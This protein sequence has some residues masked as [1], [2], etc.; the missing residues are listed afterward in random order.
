MSQNSPS[1]A[2]RS[3]QSIFDSALEAYKKKTGKDLT[4]DPLLPSLET[5]NSPDA[6]LAI[7]RAQILEPGQPQSSRNKLTMWLDPIVNVL[8]A[9]TATTG[10]FV[11]LAYPPVGVIFTG[12]GVLLSAA[13]GISADRGALID[14]FERIENIFRRLETYIEVPP[15]PGMTDA[16]VTVMVEVLR[17][18][19]IATKEVEQNRAKKFM[20]KLVGRTD[21]EDAL[22]RLEKVTLEEARMATAEALKAIHGVGNQVGDK[23]DGV[24]DKLKIVEDKM[25]V[26]EGILQCVDDKVKEIS[27]KVITEDQSRRDAVEWLSPPDPSINYNIARDTHHKGTGLWFTESSVFRDWKTSGSLLWINGKPGSGKSVLTSAIIQDIERISEAGS[28]HMAYF[29]FDFKDTGKQDSPHQRGAQRPSDSALMQ[30]L[31]KMF[32]VTEFPLYLIELVELHLANLRLCITSRS[33]VD[34]RN[35]LEPLTSISNRISLHDEVGQKKDIAEYISSIVYS[36]KKIMRWREEDKDLVVKTLSDR[37][38][39]MFRWV[40]CQIE[41]LRRCLAPSL[42][43]I[44]EELPKPWMRHMSGYYKKSYGQPTVRPLRVQE[45]AE[46]LAVDFGAAGGIPKLNEDWRW[47]DQEQAVLTACSSLI[48]VVDFRDSQIVQFSHYSVKEFLT[49]DR[50]AA[51]EMIHCVTIIFDLNPRILL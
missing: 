26:V 8:N 42:R 3:Y 17:I 43:H 2:S 25:R 31:E 21:I 24:Q 41:A 14:L 16:I 6:V 44:L 13:Q 15:T 7:L 35:V 12:I 19:G 48:A 22:Q 30:C 38:D 1:V 33:E 47:K 29:F 20:K 46:V 40:S 36:D 10:G 49:S 45:L 32:K 37:A 4:S 28:A 34:I 50:L 5:C 23:V 51:A 27:N 9:V 11:G 39:G 18:L